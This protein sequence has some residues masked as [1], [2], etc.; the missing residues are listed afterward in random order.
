MAL[1]VEPAA[2]V[3]GQCQGQVMWQIY[4]NMGHFFLHS[5]SI[6]MFCRPETKGDSMIIM[7]WFAT[8]A[9]LDFRFVMWI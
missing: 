8:S 4:S 5:F 6:W 7:L 9:L 2:A 3:Q 1:R